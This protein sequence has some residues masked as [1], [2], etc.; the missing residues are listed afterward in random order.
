[1]Y[2]HYLKQMNL[3]TKYPLIQEGEKLKF[4]YLKT[5]NTI[6]EDVISFPIRLPKEF[7]LENYIDYD[8]Q[9]EKSFVEPIKTILQSIGWTVEKQNTLESFF[10]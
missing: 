5:P 2:N 3:T 6:K 1:L 4:V 7:S 10:G 8:T 9:F